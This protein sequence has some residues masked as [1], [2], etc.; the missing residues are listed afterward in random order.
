MLLAIPTNIRLDWKSLTGKHALAYLP[1]LQITTVK[2]FITLWVPGCT[3]CGSASTGK[4]VRISVSVSEDLTG[5]LIRAGVPDS[6]DQDLVSPVWRWSQN[7]YLMFYVIFERF[8]TDNEPLT[9][10]AM[11]QHAL[12]KCKQLFEYQHLLLL[13]VQSSNLYL[14]VVNFFNTS[15]N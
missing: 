8:W 12:K 4:S 14:N 7:S 11:E 6:M 1:H 2:S 5:T 9:F 13:R 10:R 15:V 3:S